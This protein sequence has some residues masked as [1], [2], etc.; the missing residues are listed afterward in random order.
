[1]KAAITKK[2]NL[3]TASKPIVFEMREIIWV[4]KLIEMHRHKRSYKGIPTFFRNF[5]KAI[6][7]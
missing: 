4:L 5:N 2:T 6:H 1:M 7:K 3:V